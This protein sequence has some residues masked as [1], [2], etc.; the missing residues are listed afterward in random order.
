MVLI[1]PSANGYCEHILEINTNSI[2]KNT[3]AHSHVSEA[4]LESAPYL[5]ARVKASC[6]LRVWLPF[7]VD[8]VNEENDEGLL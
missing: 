7:S 3:I 8:A 5:M 6:V 4:L 1:F 2:I